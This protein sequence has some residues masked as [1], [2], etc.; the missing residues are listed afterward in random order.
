MMQTL[1]NQLI[2]H[3]IDGAPDA[4]LVTNRDRQIF[5]VNKESCRFLGLRSEELIGRTIEE[6]IPARCKKRFETMNLKLFSSIE[7]SIK[8]KEFSLVVL[9]KNN[10][11]RVVTV[12][13]EQINRDFTVF[14]LREPSEVGILPAYERNLSSIS[15]SIHDSIGQDLTAL[16]MGLK[17]I[18]IDPAEKNATARRVDSI[19]KLASKIAKDIHFLSSECK[20]QTPDDSPLSLKIGIYIRSWS[21]RTAIPV[22]FLATV[23]ETLSLGENFDANLYRITQAVLTVMENSQSTKMLDLLLEINNSTLNLLVEQIGSFLDFDQ[24]EASSHSPLSL[25]LKDLRSRVAL[26]HGDLSL[27]SKPDSGTTIIVSFPVEKNVL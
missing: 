24:L 27:D 7:G 14:R 26:F 15:K 13:L 20:P 11:E 22:D 2:E 25:V 12:N 17:T 10:K 18:H 1:D 4:I 6:L 8:R 23:P 21:N 5:Y 9:Q 19:E 16:R 3:L